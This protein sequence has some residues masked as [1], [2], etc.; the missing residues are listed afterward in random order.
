MSGR[1]P[2]GRTGTVRQRATEPGRTGREL[3]RPISI[4]NDCWIG[5]G[6]I[7]APGVTIG[8]RCIIGAGAVV[9]RDIPADTI[10]VGN[11]ATPRAR[12]ST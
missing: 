2:A 10:A 7:V 5:G 8:D 9:T 12:E 4:G 3:A 11:P 1:L 6:A